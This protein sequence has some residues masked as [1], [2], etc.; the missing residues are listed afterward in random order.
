MSFLSV[1]ER[2]KLGEQCE[3]CFCW[4]GLSLVPNNNKGF[5]IKNLTSQEIFVGAWF[6]LGLCLIL[7]LAMTYV[8]MR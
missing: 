8:T 4:R 1:L 7:A 2:I 5:L 6:V 3:C